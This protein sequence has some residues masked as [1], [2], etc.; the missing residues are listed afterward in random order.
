MIFQSLS[1]QEGMYLKKFI[2]DKSTLIYS[3]KNSKGKTTLLRFIL[4][5][6]GYNIPSTKK[7]NF[8]NFTTELLLSNN[9][10]NYKL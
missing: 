2:F 3:D 8:N 4:Y 7:I 10:I 1:L 9:N 5:S 6:I